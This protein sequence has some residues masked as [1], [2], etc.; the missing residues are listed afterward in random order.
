MAHFNLNFRQVKG[1]IGD[2]NYHYKDLGEAT[3][4]ANQVIGKSKMEKYYLII[5]IMLNL[6]ISINLNL[7]FH[8]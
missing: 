3:F 8:D 1:I 7:N 4:L 2:H 6:I 5:S